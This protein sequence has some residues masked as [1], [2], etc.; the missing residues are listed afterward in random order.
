MC[1]LALLLFPTLPHWKTYTLVHS[2]CIP[3]DNYVLCQ[4]LMDAWPLVKIEQSKSLIFEHPSPL[5]TKTEHDPY[6]LSS[7]NTTKSIRSL[8]HNVKFFQYAL[9]AATTFNFS[10]N[11]ISLSCHYW[12]SAKLNSCFP[13]FKRTKPYVNDSVYKTNQKYQKLSCLGYPEILIFKLKLK[14]RELENW[15]EYKVQLE[16]EEG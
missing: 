2:C 11:S 1:L 15:S 4:L 14:F 13:Q 16:E 12:C 9:P 10:F 3:S 6:M 5:I 8:S 7:C